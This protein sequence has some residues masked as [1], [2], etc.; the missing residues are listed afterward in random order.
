M[1]QGVIVIHNSVDEPPRPTK[2]NLSAAAGLQTKALLRRIDEIKNICRA[3]E[4]KLDT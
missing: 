3:R 4:V 2:N 1:D